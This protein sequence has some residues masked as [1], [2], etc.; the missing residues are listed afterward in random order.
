[1]KLKLIV[2]IAIFVCL[3]LQPCWAKEPWEFKLTWEG[4]PLTHTPFFLM[5]TADLDKNGLQE[6][7]VADFGRF[8]DKIGE[9]QRRKSPFYNLFVLEWDKKELKKKWAKQ[10]DM[11]KAKTDVEA[12]KYFSA[13]EAKQI[14]AW[15]VGDRVVVETIPPY[16]GLEWIGG[17][18]VLKEQQGPYN[19]APLVG[20]WALP[21]LTPAC[22]ESF[23]NFLSWP[24]ECLIAIRDFSGKGKPKIVTILEDK[25][26]E[27]QYKQKIRVRKF[28]PGFAIE[29]ETTTPMRFVLTDPLD[30][31]NWKSAELLIRGFRTAS[32]Y[33][34]S[35][36][37][38]QST[39][40]LKTIPAQGAWDIELYDLPTLY[41]RSTQK[42]GVEE[43]WGYHRVDLS[44]PERNVF[45]LL[46][47]KVTLKPDRTAFVSEVIDFPHHE[48]FLGV[49]YFD[50][51]DI[52]NDGLDEVILVEETG[53]P[54]EGFERFEYVDVKDYIRILK[55]NGKEYQTMWVGPPMK[56]R[57]AKVL[58]EDIKGIGKKQ[59][60]VLTGLGTVQ[61][62]EK[63]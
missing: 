23:I 5:T 1:M 40:S 20:S 27:K 63:Q 26:G 31:L 48:P 8:G 58:I 59:L 39:Y 9:W 42:K 25:V 2:W 51:K 14:S 7:V 36:D 28:E 4:P 10:W 61:I 44:T 33:I 62:W 6:I 47:K 13:Y 17:K 24:R 41:L 54:V 3:F 19:E 53:K 57:G 21:W 49:G 43:Y 38:G 50:L 34:L 15:S 22:Y 11:K 16:F 52:D 55:W 18:F 12:S 60:V 30:R 29:W 35:Q 56:E 32:F 37:R 45:K 46:L